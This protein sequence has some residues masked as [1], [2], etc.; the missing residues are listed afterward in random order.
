[1]STTSAPTM[2]EMRAETNW[3]VLKSYLEDGKV[4]FEDL[5]LPCGICRD[6]MTVLPSQHQTDEDGMTHSAMIF[7]CGHIFGKSCIELA[8]AEGS[9]LGRVCFACRADITYTECKHVHAGTSVPSTKE[10]IKDIPGILSKEGEMAERC[11]GCLLEYTSDKLIDEVSKVNASREDGCL[12]GF[13]CRHPPSGKSKSWTPMRNGQ[14]CTVQ[15]GDTAICK[16]TEEAMW[17]VTDF[18]D[19][20]DRINSGKCW[21][22]EGKIDLEWEFYLW[23]PPM[24]ENAAFHEYVDYKYLMEGET[25]TGMTMEELRAEF[26]GKHMPLA[27]PKTRRLMDIYL[28][29]KAQGFDD[30]DDDDED[31]D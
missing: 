20:Q 8:F 23:N 31:E 10:G 21:F 30:D 9:D 17:S 2:N 7:P 15:G 16:P 1:M 11:G 3:P 13:T 4:S 26:F 25:A 29:L 24:T 6:T 5:K 14:L 18:Q 27:K 28:E 12:M 19:E 22:Q